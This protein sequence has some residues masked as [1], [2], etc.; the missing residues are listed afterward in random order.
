MMMSS[1]GMDTLQGASPAAPQGAPAAPQLTP[2][3][4]PYESASNMF[5]G[6]GNA[7]SA[8]A[9]GGGLQNINSYLNPYYSQVVDRALGRMSTDRDNTLNL[10]GDQAEAAGAFGGSRH[11]LMEGKYLGEHNQNV[12]DLTANLQSQNFNQASQAARRDMLAGASGMGNLG[13]T[14]YNVGNNI[15]DRQASAGQQQQS[16]IQALLT[17]GVDQYN[18]M[19]QSP[20]DML[21]LFSA[22]LGADPR[23]ASGT[24]TS[25]TT[26]GL[27]DYLSLAAGVA[28]AG[29][30]GGAFGP[31]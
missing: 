2:A 3:A 29:F 8:L 7:Y 5:S 6:A 16:F 23:R 13:Q 26:P 27:F 30:S 22:I 20:Q 17:G 19:I 25:Q 18:K 11:G 31:S 10:I 1:A 21:S 4:N 12:G 28:G 15:A 14:Y 24:Q 9:Q